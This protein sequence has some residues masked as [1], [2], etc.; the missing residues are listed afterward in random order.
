MTHPEVEKLMKMVDEYANAEATWATDLASDDLLSR[1][2]NT[3]EAVVRHLTT[4][5][6]IAVAA[7]EHA[8]GDGEVTIRLRDALAAW[9]S[10]APNPAAGGGDEK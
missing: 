9:K 3:R 8:N 7:E 5:V 10:R 4:L 2:Q 6:Q 1:S